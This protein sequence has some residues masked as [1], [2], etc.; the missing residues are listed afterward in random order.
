MSGRSSSSAVGPVKRNSPFSMNTARSASRSATLIDCSTTTIVSPVVVD[1]VHDVDELAD[2][3]RRQAE[4]QLVDEQQLRVGDERLADGEHLL[5]AA[6]EV[7]G[8]LVDALGEP[9]EHGRAPAPRPPRT[10]AASLRFS[11]HASRR[12]SRTVS[13]GNTLLPPG[14]ITTPRSAISLVGMLGDVLAGEA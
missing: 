4:R 2:D 1:L 5:L 12:L 7:A 14:I 8:E 3:R 6:G 10:A 11:Q 13:V 9:R